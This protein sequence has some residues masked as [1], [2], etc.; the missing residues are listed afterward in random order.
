MEQHHIENLESII[1][2]RNLAE[3][4]M[5]SISSAINCSYVHLIDKKTAEKVFKHSL[6]AAIR[7][8]NEHPRGRLL[9][10]L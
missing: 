6:E 10:R 2:N 3:A 5:R 8:I 9:Q 4:F 7:D 1:G